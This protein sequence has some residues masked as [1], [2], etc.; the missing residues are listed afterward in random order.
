MEGI[1]ANEEVCRRYVETS[2]GLVTALVPVLGYE[3]CSGLAKMAQE[4]GRGIYELVLEKQ[5]LSKEELDEL[6]KPENMIKPR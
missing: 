4:T 5:L 6:M 3:V 2:I 1:T